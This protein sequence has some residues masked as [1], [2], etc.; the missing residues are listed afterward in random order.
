MIKALIV[1]DV[2]MNRDSLEHLV[3]KFCPQ[4]KVVGK[5]ASADEGVVLV[6]EHRPDLVFLDIEMPGGSGF[7]FLERVDQ[8]DFAIIFV[9]AFDQYAVRAFKVSALDYLMKPIN[10][11]DLIDAVEKVPERNAQDFGRQIDLLRDLVHQ[12]SQVRRIA[13]S[14][15]KGLKFMNVEDLVRMEADGKYTQCY[16]KAGKRFLSSKNL[17]EFETMLTEE[18]FIRVHH[19]HLVN[20]NYIEDYQKESLELTL[21]TGEQI[22]VSQRKREEFLKRLRL[23]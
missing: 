12:R 6:R 14:T 2:K 13:I 16:D 1:D 20:M 17:K 11:Q 18:D 15:P 21:T 3:H 23:I 5:A 8:V 19:S 4:I 10:I 7:D 22:P 9:T